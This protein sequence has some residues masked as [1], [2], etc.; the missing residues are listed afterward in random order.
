M[1]SEARIGEE[2]RHMGENKGAYRRLLVGNETRIVKG[3]R[4]TA[5]NK[6]GKSLLVKE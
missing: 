5:A 3:L 2:I 1:G 4:H 6:E